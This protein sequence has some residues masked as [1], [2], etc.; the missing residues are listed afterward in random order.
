VAGDCCI[1]V[2]GPDPL[3]TDDVLDE[4]ALS[5]AIPTRVTIASLLRGFRR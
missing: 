2:I 4:H 1:Q 5:A 3:A